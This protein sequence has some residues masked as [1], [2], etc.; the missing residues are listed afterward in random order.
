M[1]RASGWRWP[2]SGP[3]G[4]RA[5]RR[6]RPEALSLGGLI[7]EVGRSRTWNPSRLAVEPGLPA[8]VEKGAWRGARLPAVPA[9]GSPPSGCRLL[10]TPGTGTRAGD[11]GSGPKR[12]RC[13]HPARAGVRLDEPVGRAGTRDEASTTPPRSLRGQS[14]GALFP[15]L[16]SPP[17]SS[18]AAAPAHLA[19]GRG[20]PRLRDPGRLSRM[21]RGLEPCSCH[22]RSSLC[23][24]P[25]LHQPL[26]PGRPHPPVPPTAAFGFSFQR[27][28]SLLRRLSL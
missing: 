18:S 23:C 24:C 17:A 3:Q 28:L 26:K 11:L 25:P 16:P 1:S 22:G 19:A 7:C 9:G 8:R 5:E 12:R 20:A 13:R 14:C 27:V 4:P 15:F 10:A 6:I 21:L 2:V